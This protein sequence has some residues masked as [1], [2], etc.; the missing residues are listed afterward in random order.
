MIEYSVL[1]VCTG[2]TCRSPMAEGLAKQLLAE[3]K[4]VPVAHLEQAGVRVRSAGVA[5]AGGSRATPEAVEAMRQAGV[6]IADHQ[7]T[8]LHADLIQD[9]DV[10]YTMTNGHRNA[11]AIF[12]ANAMSKTHQLLEDQDVADPIGG[13]QSL[14]LQTAEMIRAG[15]KLRIAERYGDR[16]G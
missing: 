16:V 6:D 2:N 11:V 4:G 8:P 14:Y 1:F 12:D 9:A 10:I 7:S 5:T 13:P 15:L 3:L